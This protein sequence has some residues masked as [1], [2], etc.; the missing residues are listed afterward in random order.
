MR[1]AGTVMVLLLL[2]ACSG[3]ATGP[4]SPPGPG[5]ILIR[6]GD[7]GTLFE[8]F[9]ITRDDAP[10]TDAVVSVNGTVIATSATGHY[11][12]QLPAILQPGEELV[13]RVVAGGDVAEARA[14]IPTLPVITSPVAGQA[15]TSGSA[16][17]YTWTAAADPDWWKIDA[18]Y[19][20]TSSGGNLEVDSLAAAARSG[21]LSTAGLPATGVTSFAARLYA[22]L[23]GT[24][25]GTVDPQSNMRVRI[26]ANSVSL[27]P[28]P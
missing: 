27:T 20:T 22:Y 13:L 3:D 16:V 21:S 9:D 26:T 25:T 10:L 6:G 4:N 1:T 14:T 28:D 15:V 19:T 17:A 11:T 12:Y 24:F 23:H 18:F 5:P 2:A 7:M 8:N